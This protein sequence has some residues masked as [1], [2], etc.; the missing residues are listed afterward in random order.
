MKP[1]SF[2]FRLL[3][4]NLL[5]VL[6]IVCLG[7]AIAYTFL[8]SRY[9]QDNRDKQ[10]RML[11]MSQQFFQRLWPQI[12]E[13]GFDQAAAQFVGRGPMRLTVVS[14]DGSV[15]ADTAPEAD[16]ERMKNHLTPDRPEIIAAAEGSHGEDQRTSRTLGVPFR[17]MAQPVRVDGE[18]VGVVR[19]AMPVRSIAQEA[20]FLRH[21]LAL[22]AGAGLAAALSLGL[23]I[24]WMWYKPLRRISQTARAIAS[25]DLSERALTTGPVELARLGQALNEMRRSLAD[26]IDTIAAARQNLQTVLANLREGVLAL[27][28]DGTVVLANRSARQLILR[29]GG[30]VE[31]Q[32]I[33]SVV[34]V[35]QALEAYRDAES[36]GRPVNRQAEITRQR[37]R[38][39]LDIHARRVGVDGSGRISAIVVVRD[40]TEM[41]RA[42][43]MKADFVANASHEL[44]T[45]LA[46][47]RAAVDS[48]GTLDADDPESFQKVLAIL[49]RHANR[50]ENMANDLLDLHTIESG[51]N[52]LQLEDVEL[53]HLGQWLRAHFEQWAQEKDVE[54]KISTEPEDFTFRSDRKLLEMIAQ[55]LL[56]NAIKFTPSGGEVT[57]T[58]KGEDETATLE[59]RD[60]GIGIGS[61]EQ[62]KV[63]ERFY[64][65]D[66]A[67]SGDT[68]IRGTGLGLAIVKHAAERLGASIDLT[69]QSGQGTTITVTFPPPA[70][71]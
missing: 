49:D 22:A 62:G 44:R 26:Q 68:R 50:L 15:L 67:R 58:L 31:G 2:F 21:A 41:A 46:T 8:D 33:R 23:L 54:L 25:G 59:V 45:P 5:L 28:S 56:D 34:R 66:Q 53:A 70:G 16:A 19:L 42:T 20:A 69:S 12:Q 7:G 17:Y 38:V 48:L 9:Q 37:R 10:Q 55:N 36:G 43:S 47:I 64:Q 30:P 61:D 14:A 18:V 63:F 29:E 39:H 11:G 57:V 51:R 32:N 13:E 27:D 4:G 71:L 24:S 52:R 6:T 65:S 40:V 3:V 1:R 60:T 35:A